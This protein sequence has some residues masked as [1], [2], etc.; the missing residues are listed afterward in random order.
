M[1]WSEPAGDAYGRAE[2][3]SILTIQCKAG[4]VLDKGIN[5]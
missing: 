1:M 4:Y 5:H 3:G 2:E